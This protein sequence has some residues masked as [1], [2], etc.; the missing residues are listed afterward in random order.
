MQERTVN[1]EMMVVFFYSNNSARDPFLHFSRLV[2]RLTHL[3]LRSAPAS[4]S[5]TRHS[6]CPA[7]CRG[8]TARRRTLFGDYPKGEIKNF[9]HTVTY[10]LVRLKQPA[11]FCFFFRVSRG[12]SNDFKFFFAVLGSLCVTR[13]ASPRPWLRNVPPSTRADWSHLLT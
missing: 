4:T 5:T 3:A 13:V 1:D 8:S 6:T 12:T 11:C 10:S 9:S 2:F 7:E